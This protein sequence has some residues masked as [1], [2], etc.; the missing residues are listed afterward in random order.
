MGK[1]K[2]Q[3]ADRK[4]KRKFHGNRF[5]RERAEASTTAV[6]ESEKEKDLVGQ[7]DLSS[8]DQ[9]IGS[10]TCPNKTAS[11]SK[12]KF[13]GEEA[14]EEFDRDPGLTGFRFV[15]VELL[16]DFIQ[17]LLCPRCRRPLGENKRQA[18]VTEQRSV[19][20]SQFTFHCQCQHSVTLNTSK[21]CG[22]THEVSRRFPLS[23]FSIGK[24][25]KHGQK[26]LGSMNMP[27]SVNKTV[28]YSTDLSEL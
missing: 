26:F 16:V 8:V 19:L 24:N 2:H 10:E 28:W 5:T 17:S 13:E 20:A 23:I 9:L 22:K 3:R 14:Q 18:H 11:C 7:T 27:Y 15:D 21:K 1:V 4:K 6:S 25:L 12:V